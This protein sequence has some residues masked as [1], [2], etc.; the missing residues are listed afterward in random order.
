MN[1]KVTINSPR[2]KS[3]DKKTAVKLIN[4]YAE[5]Y[6]KK[7]SENAFLQRQIEDLQ[8]NL[9]L[10]KNIINTFTMNLPPNEKASELIKKLSCEI[11]E[12]YSMNFQL[13]SQLEESNNK[14]RPILTTYSKD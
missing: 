9:M 5:S 11:N 1:S 7:E 2:A 10:N 8:N 6:K 13:R 3:V 14:V 4:N 12:L